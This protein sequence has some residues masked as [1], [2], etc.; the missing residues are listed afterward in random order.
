MHL[1]RAVQLIVQFCVKESATIIKCTQKH[2]HT[3]CFAKRI[4]V[5]TLQTEIS[6][7]ATSTHLFYR[8][9]SVFYDGYR[10]EEE[11]FHH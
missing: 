8:S 1:K 11:F 3:V 4:T 9:P 6:A 7:A 10:R 2:R 5:A